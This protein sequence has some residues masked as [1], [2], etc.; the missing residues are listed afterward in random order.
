[1][2]KKELREVCL[3]SVSSVT[4]YEV[5]FVLSFISD[6][7]RHWKLHETCRSCPPYRGISRTWYLNLALSICLFFCPSVFF[8]SDCFLLSPTVFHCLSSPFYNF[9]CPS[10][11]A[12]LTV[13][14]VYCLSLCLILSAS[15]PRFY[16]LFVSVSIFYISFI[17]LN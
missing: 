13:I 7:W 12:R 9:F 5:S 11:S 8:V 4:R 2:N 6:R 3:Q 14:M 16:F 17:F 1:M 15:I 10:F